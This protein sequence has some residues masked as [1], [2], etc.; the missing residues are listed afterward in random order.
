MGNPMGTSGGSGPI[1]RGVQY[2]QELRMVNRMVK[3]PWEILPNMPKMDDKPMGNPSKMPKMDGLSWEILLKW[4]VTVP[5]LGVQYPEWMVYARGNPKIEWMMTG[6]TPILGH[7]HLHIGI[8]GN[9]VVRK[10]TGNHWLKPPMSVSMF[11]Q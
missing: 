6:R 11:L 4:M 7:P 10:S 2:P 3:N 1:G 9:I 5:N 8:Q